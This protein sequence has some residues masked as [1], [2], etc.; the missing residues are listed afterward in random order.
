MH[1][2]TTAGETQMVLFTYHDQNNVQFWAKISG[3]C[4]GPASTGNGDRR[5]R[6]KRVA[7]QINK[8]NPRLLYNP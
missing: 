3:L 1:S 4:V 2:H 7:P 8:K 5:L 6:I